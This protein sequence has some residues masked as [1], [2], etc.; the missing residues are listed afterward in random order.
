[1]VSSEGRWILW[2]IKV[3]EIESAS[4]IQKTDSLG[5]SGVVIDYIVETFTYHHALHF[6]VKVTPIAIAL[7]PL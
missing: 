5:L 1:M 7:N 6:P 2:D 4:S 3:A